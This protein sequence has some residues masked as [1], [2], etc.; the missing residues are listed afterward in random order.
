MG[1]DPDIMR[2]VQ[3]PVTALVAAF[4]AKIQTLDQVRV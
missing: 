3:V 1:T 4:R 2:N